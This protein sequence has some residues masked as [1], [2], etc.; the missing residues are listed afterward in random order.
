MLTSRELKPYKFDD[1]IFQYVA[2]EVLNM[3]EPEVLLGQRVSC[4]APDI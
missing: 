1:Q 4:P 2:K 3:V